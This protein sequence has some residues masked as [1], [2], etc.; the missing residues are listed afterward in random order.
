MGDQTGS[1]VITVFVSAGRDAHEAERLLNGL[2]E[3][4]LPME[5][6]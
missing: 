4:T 1:D 2:S 6:T 5:V 3:T